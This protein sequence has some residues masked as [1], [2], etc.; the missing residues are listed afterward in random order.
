MRVPMICVA[1]A[2]AA[3]FG[4]PAVVAQAAVPVHCGAVLTVSTHLTQ[5][6]TCRSGVGLTL[7]G[8][9]TLDLGGHRLTGPG[10]SA[11][12]FDTSRGIALSESG[13]PRIQHG[14]IRGWGVGTGPSDDNSGFG[15]TRAA[16]TGVTYSDNGSGLSG[17]TSTFTVSRSRFVHN[18]DN[19]ITG[20][21]TVATVTWSVFLDNGR[22]ISLSDGGSLTLSRSLVARNAVGVSCDEVGCTITLSALLTNTTAISTFSTQAKITANYIDGNKVGFD[23][24]FD[25]NPGYA[26]ELS[27]NS[28]RHN[29]TG[30]VLSAYGS[31][32]LH[33]N[34]FAD[35]GVG[36]SVAA[37]DSPPTA[38]LV[39]NRFTRNHDGVLVKAAG[40]SLK[41]NRAVDNT[42]YGIYAVQAKDLGGNIAYGNG[43]RGQCSG[44]VCATHG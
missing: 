1:V 35:N 15:Q 31:G 43:F 17:S 16:V 8:N 42:R 24:S 2:V 11:G 26:N 10:K 25:P 18:T 13:T 19:G 40:M 32:F 6:L 39:A 23:A 22:A 21:T 20:L 30:V 5:D 4:F 7:R 14:T 33:D 38:L 29:G 36:F 37:S 44:V 27:H 28:I 34:Y 41:S 9:I 12:S 3:V